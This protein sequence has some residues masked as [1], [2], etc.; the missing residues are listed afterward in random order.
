MFFYNSYYQKDS[1]NWIHKYSGETVKWSSGVVS[2]SGLTFYD[3]LSS[4]SSNPAKT[5]SCSLELE[6]YPLCSVGLG[7]VVFVSGYLFLFYMYLQVPSKVVSHWINISCLFFFIDHH[8][9]QESNSL[10]EWS[11]TVFNCIQRTEQNKMLH[12]ACPHVSK[13]WVSG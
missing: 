6:T 13:L 2:I 11:Q 7:Q 8:G 3:C 10:Q 12:V 1:P 4:T 5:T 9:Y